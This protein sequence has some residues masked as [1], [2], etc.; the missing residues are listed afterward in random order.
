MDTSVAARLASLHEQLAATYRD[1]ARQGQ[2]GTQESD[3][4]IGLAE[5]ATRILAELDAFPGTLEDYL[6]QWISTLP[7]W[8]RPAGW[9]A[10]PEPELEPETD[11]YMTIAAP[12][13]LWETTASD[14]SD[15]SDPNP[16]TFPCE[17][18]SRKKSW[19]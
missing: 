8:V 11:P 5:A 6:D 4:V 9:T 1:L 3:R 18:S 15:V 12:P 19:K 7:L 2:P 10:Q 14:V 13:R 16:K 17:V